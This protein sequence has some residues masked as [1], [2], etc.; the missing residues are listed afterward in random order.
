MNAGAK[1]GAA[2]RGT[3]RMIGRSAKQI[4]DIGFEFVTEQKFNIVQVE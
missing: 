2:P 1:L 4:V 3:C